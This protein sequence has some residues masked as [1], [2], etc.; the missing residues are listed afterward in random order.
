MKWEPII[1]E[2]KLK[3]GEWD[4]ID[5]CDIGE[6]GPIDRHRER[7]AFNDRG[8]YL[9]RKYGVEYATR[10]VGSEVRLFARWPAW[11]A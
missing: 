3:P 8:N 10:L 2:L 6:M 9:A 11:R 4:Q 5:S 1:A 7:D